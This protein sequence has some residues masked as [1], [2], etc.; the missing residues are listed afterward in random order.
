MKVMNMKHSF[1]GMWVSND[2]THNIMCVCNEV[3][4]HS[5]IGTVVRMYAQ[6]L[7]KENDNASI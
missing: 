3:L 1:S 2:G 7:V 6:H 5:R 4:T